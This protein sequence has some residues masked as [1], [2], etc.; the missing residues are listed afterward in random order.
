MTDTRTRVTYYI[1]RNSEQNEGLSNTIYI[2]TKRPTR[3]TGPEDDPYVRW[4]FIVDGE[5][6]YDDFIGHATL[7]YSYAEFNVIPDNDDQLI[8]INRGI[9][10]KMKGEQ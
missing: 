7:D 8:R 10:I 5:W 4:G 9:P 2:W 6:S 1:T 3:Y